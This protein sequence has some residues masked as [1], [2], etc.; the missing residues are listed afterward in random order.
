MALPVIPRRLIGAAAAL[1]AVVAFAPAAALAGGEDGDGEDRREIDV[2]G[3][4][5]AASRWTLHLEVREDEIR[6]EAVVRFS[7]GRGTVIWR[8]VTLHERR[9]VKRETVRVPRERGQ[10]RVRAR[11]PNYAGPDAIVIRLV[12]PA[13]ESCPAAA[14]G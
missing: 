8:A 12:G 7:P 11:V 5:G 14:V 9:L 10:V 6:A 3:R 1:V 2:A 4:C 13:G